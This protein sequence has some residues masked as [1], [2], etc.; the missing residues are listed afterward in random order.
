MHSLNIHVFIVFMCV[1]MCMYIS[2]GALR[3]QKQ[4]GLQLPAM[5]NSFP[6]VG[7]GD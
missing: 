2:A 4:L 1:I 6:D 5:V 3:G 7:A